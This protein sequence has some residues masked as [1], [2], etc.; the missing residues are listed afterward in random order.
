MKRVFLILLFLA[1]PLSA[2][3]GQLVPTSSGR[4]DPKV[5]S[6]RE[7][8]VDVGVA[9][10]YARVSV[11]QVFENHTGDIQEGTW[12]F[13]LPPSGA[14]GDFAVW[15]G[16]VRIP[17]VI[18]EKKR[19]RAIYQDLTTQRIDPGLLQQGDEDDS[20]SG[21]AGG[22]SSDR[23][24]GGALFSVSVAPIPAWGTKRLEMQYQQDVP[25]VNGTGELR[26]PL[27]P[28]DGEAMVAGTFEI[29]VSVLDGTPS[30]APKSALPLQTKGTD[31]FFRGTNVK[32]DKDVVVRFKPKATSP[33]GFTAF[34]NPA[35]SLPDG[36]AL[37]PWERPQE[38]PPE[39]DGFFLVEYFPGSNAPAS[40][41]TAAAGKPEPAQPARGPVDVVFLF[42]TSLSTRWSGL[43][44]AFA[45]LTKTLD[46]LGK[47]DRFALLAFDRTPAASTP[48]LVAAT[49]EAKRAA[50]DFL[51]ARPLSPGTDPVAAVKAGAALLSPTG[52]PR[53]PRLVLFTDGSGPAGNVDA[54]RSGVPLFTLLS[55]DERREAYSVASTAI[56][57]LTA[58]ARPG[59][60]ATAE[61]VLFTKALFQTGAER[62]AA[63]RPTGS[64]MP[65]TL[66]GGDPKVRDVYSVLV[67]PPVAG[68]LSGYVGRYAVPVASTTLT[69]A[70]PLPA[71]STKAVFPETALEARDL[72]RRWARARVDD[73]LARIEREGEKREWV[74]E[75]LDLSRRYKFVTPYTAFLAAPRSLLR[76]RRIQP[77][78]PVI[79]C[80]ADA[81]I[82][83]ITALL[84]YGER[85]TLH[86]RPKSTLWEG[87]FLVPEGLKDGRLAVRL[88]LR[89]ASGATLVET[90]HVVLDGTAP[91][92]LPE[93]LAA[94]ERGKTL[95]VAARADSDTIVLTARL[96]DGPPVPLRWD[97]ATKTSIADVPVPVAMASRGDV[98]FEAVD[99]AGNHGFARS[100]VNLAEA[101]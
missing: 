50:L 100:T 3:T 30:P 61:E 69:L 75:I 73:L 85:V 24:S 80:E 36:L 2:Q 62:P 84:P 20:A 40:A 58:A 86:R 56:L 27:R 8:S 76:P 38:V 16:N 82:T 43:E 91:K 7:M 29:R 53:S 95:R 4:P 70:P 98:F 77:G 87:R 81:G 6:L 42:D 68:S 94:A 52:K 41:V 14:V 11:R 17:G 46:G 78:D 12:R 88:V 57:N 19:A 55:G 67:Q 71:L 28:T 35:G 72:P 33:L 23:P 54:A 49:P 13:A 44:R 51:R 93:K 99:G 39:K 15:D 34:R 10:G 48:G 25:W 18:L 37:A 92:I 5:L 21:D 96:G 9:R 63:P 79:R 1:L 97:S 32:L 22:R 47:D 31:S 66:T 64:T 83:S 59:E 26:I 45:G 74:E 60:E 101:R 90:K 65:F 89:D